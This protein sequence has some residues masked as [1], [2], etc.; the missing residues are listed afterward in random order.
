M[1]PAI[2]VLWKQALKTFTGQSSP[3]FKLCPKNIDTL[4][5]LMNKITAADFYMNDRLFEAVKQRRS[6]ICIMDIYENNDI[7]IVI[8]MLKKGIAMPLHD[9]PGMHGFLKVIHGKAQVSSL[10]LKPNSNPVTAIDEGIIAYKHRPEI[11]T[12]NSPTCTLKPEEKNIHEVMCIEEPATFLDILSPPY[13]R[14]PN[15]GL[16]ECTF[17]KIIDSKEHI[18]SPDIIEEVKLSVLQTLPTM[19]TEAIKYNGPPLR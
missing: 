1:T 5:E 16:R 19:Y 10:T 6:S 17:F 18:E 15:K 14:N 8:F 12:M 9:H 7:S 4:L 2:E 3:H 13:Y 11:L